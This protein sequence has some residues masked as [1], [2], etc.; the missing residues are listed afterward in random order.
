MLQNVKVFHVPVAIWMSARGLSSLR[1]FS[2]LL[3]ASI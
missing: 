1:E 2:R 3:I